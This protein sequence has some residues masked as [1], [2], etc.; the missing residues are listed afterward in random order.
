MK[1]IHRYKGRKLVHTE[2]GLEVYK[3]HTR[4]TIVIIDPHTMRQ[5]SAV[6]MPP[7]TPVDEVVQYG[8]QK[9]D[10]IIAICGGGRVRPS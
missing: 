5:L 6:Y 1:S 2:P 4:I 9:R 7:T 8:R 10:S 3:S